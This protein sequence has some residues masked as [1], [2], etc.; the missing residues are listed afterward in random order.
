[1][2]YGKRY[3]IDEDLFH[4]WPGLVTRNGGVY[5]TGSRYSG[6]DRNFVVRFG[7]SEIALFVSMYDVPSMYDWREV[8]PGTYIDVMYKNERRGKP[9][10]VKFE[11]ILLAAGAEIEPPG[12]PFEA[13][14]VSE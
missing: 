10:A 6:S 9:A 13:E 12:V 7:K 11:Q 8:P 1:M 14:S 2:L 4:D 5:R 3:R